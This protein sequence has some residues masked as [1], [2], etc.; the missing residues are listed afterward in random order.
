MALLKKG[1]ETLNYNIY[2]LPTVHI[3]ERLASKKI[4]ILNYVST[5]IVDKQ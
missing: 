1:W 5:T 4:F 3:I 2:K